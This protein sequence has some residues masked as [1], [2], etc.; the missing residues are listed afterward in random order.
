VVNLVAKTEVAASKRTKF[1]TI[2]DDQPRCGSP[3][4]RARRHGT[5]LR[6]TLQYPFF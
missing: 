4:T 3:P 5:K 1:D 6:E 2:R